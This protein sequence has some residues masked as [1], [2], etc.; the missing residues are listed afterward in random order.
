MSK[1]TIYDLL[2]K[3]AIGEITQ[4]QI[5]QATSVSDVDRATVNFW[6]G[7][8]TLQRVLELRQYPNAL[9]IPELSAISSNSVAD[10]ASAT[11]KPSGTEIYRI[12]TIKS[13]ANMMVSLYDGTTNMLIHSGTDP[14]SFANLFLTPTLYIVIQNGSGD[15]AVCN[16]AY[17]KVGL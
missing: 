7:P 14:Q 8:I 10:S 1:P 13:D 3:K 17:H 15:T 11:F 2:S 9:P 5:N 16:I 6:K 12:Q 4:T